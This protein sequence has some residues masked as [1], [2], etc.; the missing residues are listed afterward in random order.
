MKTLF[1]KARLIVIAGTLTTGLARC[2]HGHQREESVIHKERIEKSKETAD[3]SEAVKATDEAGWDSAAAYRQFGDTANTYLNRN[4]RALEKF[5]E[6]VS[7]KGKKVPLPY[8][9]RIKKLKERNEALRQRLAHPP[10][11]GGQAAWEDYTRLYNYDMQ[12]LGQDIRRLTG[13]Q[14]EEKKPQPGKGR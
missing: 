7:P 14:P 6:K 8:R 1:Y 10:A 5:E 12:R 9:K 4:T 2:G 13:Y 11:T 3:I